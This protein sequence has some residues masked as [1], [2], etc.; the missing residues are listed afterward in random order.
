MIGAVRQKEEGVPRQTEVDPRTTAEENLLDSFS[1]EEW[2]PDS[3]FNW[4]AV[5]KDRTPQTE[6]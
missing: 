3:L 6:L 2:E 4:F 1:E 5:L